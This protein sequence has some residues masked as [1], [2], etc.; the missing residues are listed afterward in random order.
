M[1]QERLYII[2]RSDLP[3]GDQAVQACHVVEKW[4]YVN[5]DTAPVHTMALLVVDDMPK[6]VGL[7]CKLMVRFVDYE[8]FEEP[9]LND[10][11]TAIACLTNKHQLFKGLKK[12]GE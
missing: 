10:E 11:P 2:T 1:Q 3:I 4:K 9:D 5:R 7:Q 6:L 12:L 8:I